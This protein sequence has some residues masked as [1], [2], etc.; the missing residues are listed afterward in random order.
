MMHF[1]VVLCQNIEFYTIAIFCLIF[2]L[3]AHYLT[4][5]ILYII[6]IVLPI[7]IT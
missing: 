6:E 7:I 2:I 4:T 1:F 3:N 5:Y